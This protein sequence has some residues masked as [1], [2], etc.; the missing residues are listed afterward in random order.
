M[1]HKQSSSYGNIRIIGGK[2]R[3]RKLPFPAIP[4]LR[5]TPNP[6]RET[7]FNWLT[8]YIV[9]STCLDLFAGSGA[10]GLEALSRGADSVTF[11]DQSRIVTN[12]L[13]EQ[14]TQ[15]K[16]T[17]AFVYCAGFN[18]IPSLLEKKLFDIVFL[19]PPFHQGFIEP[20]CA[21]LEAHQLLA[22]DALIYIETE[23]KLMPLPI[24]EYWQ[25]LRSKA[26]GQ[27]NYH[28]LQRNLT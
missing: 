2:W 13:T 25:I 16:A 6:V 24:P 5:P 21:L 20:A 3:S 9:G 19:D 11:I 17:N 1:R 10:L 26:I 28:L 18:T 23:P 8:P 12:Y 14:I 7:L 22:P 15:F 4:G 27:V